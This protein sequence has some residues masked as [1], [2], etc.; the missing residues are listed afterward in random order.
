[1]SVAAIQ[2]RP[3]SDIATAAGPTFFVLGAYVQSIDQMATW[4]SRGVN[5]LVEVP[6]GHDVGQ[7][8]SAADAAGLYQIRHPSADLTADLNDPHLL[9]WSTLDEPSNTTDGILDYGHVAE[10]PAQVAAEA[11]PWRAAAQAAG[12]FMPIWT[13]HVGPH[14]WPD[15]AQHNAL[16]YDYMQGGESDWLSA[17]SYPIQAGQNFVIQTNDGY[18]S[19]VQGVTLDRQEAWS[20]G[21]PVMAFIGTSA[22]TAGGPAP[23][24]AEFTAMA[25]SAVI[26][27]AVGVIYFPVQFQPSWS[28]DATPPDVVAAITAFNLK[29]S[30]L[31]SILMDEAHGGRNPFIVFHSANAGAAP[32]AGQL[33]YPFEAT[34]IQ[35]GQGP[36]HIVLNLSDHDQVLNMPQWGFGAATVHGYDVVM[37]Y[38]PPTFTNATYNGSGGADAIIGNPLNDRINGKGGADTIYGAAGADT[39]DGGAGADQLW[40]G[41][42]NDRFQFGSAAEANGDRIMDFAKGDLIDLS[43]IDARSATRGDDAFAF[44]GS[45]AFSGPGQLHFVQ[46]A[47]AGVTYIEGNTGGD[48][49]PEF[50]IVIKGLVTFTAS[51]FIL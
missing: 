26:H 41:A 42:G 50:V 30:G 18:T 45:S 13:N 36:F 33:S 44:I 20:G 39:L 12:K 49:T 24:G 29:I 21:K 6:E 17:D 31:D 3:M 11:A 37:G 27:G 2:D 14:I 35:T 48:A 9:A 25:W 46:D 22:F 23:T 28:F 43:A 51:D 32:L 8:I 10:D 40:G 7:W 15:W 38:T 34:E 1:M 16:M 5:T 19:T 47:A 4:K